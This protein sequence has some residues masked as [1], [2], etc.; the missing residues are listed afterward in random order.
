MTVAARAPNHLGDLVLAL[1][2]LAALR[3][4]V[5]VVRSWLAPLVGL[6]GIAG[7]VLPL[8][9]GAR[10]F[11]ATAAALRRRRAGRGVLL[12]PAFSAAALFAAGGVRRRRG[13]ATDARTWLLHDAVPVGPTAGCHRASQYLALA[14]GVTPAAPP[15]PRLDPAPARTALDGAGL[16]AI[17]GAV[18]VFPG[19]HA[20]SRRWAPARFAEVVRRLAARG[21]RVVVFGAAA[22]A[23]LTRAVAGEAALDLGGRTTLPQL[24]GALAACRL[25]V[26]NDSGPMHLAAAVGTRVVVPWGAGDPRETGPL[27]A[28]HAV[29]RAAGLP[30]MPC[31]RNV[32]P[33]TGPGTRLPAAENECLALLDVEEVW[34]T[35]EAALDAP[36]DGR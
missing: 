36:R 7:E 29:L 1:P 13:T 31:R 18:G 33:R 32:C 25:L 22:E 35:L 28:G 34:R 26:T 14:T 12:T 3:P 30:C 24:A 5:L 2:A 17:D 23:A 6:A 16:P 15:V 9:R 8:D 10:A 19:S 27:G 11:A 21:E 4:D 20:A